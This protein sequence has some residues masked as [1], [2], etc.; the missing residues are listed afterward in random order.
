MEDGGDTGSERGA[1]RRNLNDAPS[2]VSK[3]F[4]TNWLKK[5]RGS[6]QRVFT[7]KFST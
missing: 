5:P 7:H 3:S 2:V 4:I 1:K 6:S